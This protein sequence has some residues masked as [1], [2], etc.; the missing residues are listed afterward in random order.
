MLYKIEVPSWRSTGDVSIKDDIIEEIG[1]MEGYENFEIVVP[2][3]SLNNPIIQHRYQMQRN[4]KEYLSFRCGMQEIILYPFIHEKYIDAIGQEKTDL[5]TLADPPSP[6]T[7]YIRTSLIPGLLSSIEHNLKDFDKFKIYELGKVFKKNDKEVPMEENLPIQ[8]TRLSGAIVDKDANKIFYTVKGIIEGMSNI[9][10]IKEI[11]LAKLEEVK[12]LEKNAYLNIIS[13]SEVIGNMGLFSKRTLSKAGIKNTN[14]CIFDINVDKLIPNLARENEFFDLPQFPL[15][16]TD[17][18]IIVDESTTWDE[19]K[20]QVLKT[21][22]KIEFAEEYKGEQVPEN[23]KSIMF[24][25]IYDGKDRTLKEK[26]IK[27]KTNKIIS[28]LE[29]IGAY[30]RK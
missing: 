9:V 1:R 22:D 10:Q 30:I 20:E 15:V 29:K 3:V 21:A 11:E 2:K 19:I 23:K 28:D 5:I 13:N 14:V 16:K 6:E 26:D 25:M 18:S 7:K 4:L 27:E 12:Y 24:H 17:L 8:T